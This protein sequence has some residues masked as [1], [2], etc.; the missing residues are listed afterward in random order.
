MS[1][2]AALESRS[3]TN[4]LV[5]TTRRASSPLVI[6]VSGHRN[7]HS[8]AEAQVRRQI[9]EFFGALR[10]LLPDTELRIMVGMAQGADLL[11]AC[12]ALAAGWH[13]DAILPM[14]LDEYIQDFDGESSRTLVTLLRDPAVQ[15]TVLP[16]PTGRDP[17]SP[18]AAA[19]RDEL[20]ANLREALIDK[21][22]LLLALWNGQ[23]SKLPGGT[24]DTMLRYLGART[25]KGRDERRIEFVPAGAERAWGPH[26]VYWIPT[27]RSDD[28][29]TP[30][31]APRICPASASICWQL[32][33]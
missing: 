17:T 33:R 32:T 22:S 25:F 31:H 2:N 3:E 18:Q 8:D 28:V 11:V 26:F 1:G 9:D 23:A 5:D 30:S 13:V 20:Y 24:A 29:A 4:N 6:G 14:P 10:R 12:A 19:H 16:D 27:I 7:L 21:C 15:C